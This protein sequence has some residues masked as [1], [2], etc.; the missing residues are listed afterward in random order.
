MTKER[1]NSYFKTLTRLTLIFIISFAAFSKDTKKKAI[2]E[3]GYRCESCGNN[4]D[5]LYP[6]HKL[7]EQ[8]GG[9]DSIENLF[10]A[11]GDCHPGLDKKAIRHGLLADGLSVRDVLTDEP[12][13]VGDRNKFMKALRRFDRKI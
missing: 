2:E 4:E 10:L 7:P 5:Y 12:E 13:L 1:L 8:M 3:R 9:N 6:H 11:C